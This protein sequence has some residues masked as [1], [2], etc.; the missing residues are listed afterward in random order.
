M[1][2]FC[3][4]PFCSLILF[5]VSIPSL[6]HAQSG[7]SISTGD[8]P[9][10]LI[11]IRI[12]QEGGCGTAIIQGQSVDG[13]S[14]INLSIGMLNFGD[15]ANLLL[16]GFQ[17]ILN[18]GQ[19]GIQDLIDIS[20]S[21]GCNYD[22]LHVSGEISAYVINNNRNFVLSKSMGGKVSHSDQLRI[23]APKSCIIELPVTASVGLIAF[24][25]FANPD[26]SVA[27]ASADV[28]VTMGGQ[29]VSA[30]G[31]AEVKGSGL[32]TQY[33]SSTKILK[34]QLQ[35]GVNIVPLQ[36]S[37]S[38]SVSSSV[39]GISPLNV[40][41][42]GSNAT[43]TAGNSLIVGNFTGENGEPLPEGMEIIGLTSGINYTNPT[44][45]NLCTDFPDPEVT[46][47]SASCGLANGAASVEV[48]GIDNPTYLWSTGAQTNAV[49]NLTPGLRFLIVGDTASCFKY[50]P[51]TVGDTPRPSINLP[52][53]IFLLPGNTVVLDATADNLTY[54][55]STGAVTPSITVDSPG[56]YSVTVSDQFG[57]NYEYTSEVVLKEGGLTIADGNIT[58]NSGLFFDDGGE[59]QNYQENKNYVVTIC[60]ADPDQYIRLQFTEVNI[61]N[62]TQDELSIYDGVGSLCPVNTRVT[63][64][65]I[66]TAS[67]TS[68][69]C[70]TVRFRSTSQDG[71]PPGTGWKA[72]I[73]TTTFPS[74]GCI[75]EYLECNTV[76][77][78]NGGVNSNLHIGK[79]KVYYFCPENDSD[80]AI[81]DFTQVN[82]SDLANLAVYDG[83]GIQCLL[84]PRLTTP[85]KFYASDRSGGCL[86]VVYD[87]ENNVTVAEWDALFQCTDTPVSPPEY[88]KCGINPAP[89]NTCDL[90]PLLNNIEAFCGE[91]SILYTADT[92]GNLEDA[93]GCG[94]VHN[95]SF[96]KFVPNKTSVKLRYKTRG[97]INALC[98]GF[99]LAAF[100]VEEPCNS[101]NSTWIE[102]GCLQDTNTGGDSG[103]NDEGEI[104]IS[105]LL[106]GKTYY[107]MIDGSLGSECQYTLTALSGFSACPLDVEF[108]TID[109]QPDGSFYVTIPF[110][111]IGDSTSYRLI[112]EKNFFLNL[113]EAPF[114][115]DGHTQSVTIGPY[116]PGSEYHI[117]ITGGEGFEACDLL[118][119]GRSTCEIPCNLELE[120]AFDCNEQTGETTIS[121]SIPGATRPVSIY[122][123]AFSDLI[124]PDRESDFF[125]G[126]FEKGSLGET[127]QFYVQDING[128]VLQD[129]LAVPDCVITRTNGP[130][131]NDQL[132]L[133]VFPNPA[134]SH[135][136]LLI[137][138]GESRHVLE[139]RVNILDLNG[140]IRRTLPFKGQNP[141]LL[142]DISGLPNG[143]Y[144]LRLETEHGAIIRKI[145]KV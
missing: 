98:N 33:P 76:F 41:M 63:F 18:D 77:T 6:I 54:L 19:L 47:T 59:F 61:T 4:I 143:V 79:Q 31:L 36:V 101:V 112:E 68:G 44:A 104:E 69:G 88:C 12:P 57:C 17:W 67:S 130:V 29:S 51:F 99:Q 107:L 140:I 66:Y 34:Y 116:P 60:P 97:G 58:T 16:T 136:N 81:L 125:A 25:A 21:F 126:P 9:A 35:E 80:Y 111:G 7:I 123:E 78:N 27:R 114:I 28:T 46:V 37:G 20:P 105:D 50:I 87:S 15:P 10:N 144:Y 52:E 62:S 45:S 142:M 11:K 14:S 22:I 117:R 86:T 132:S 141:K 82:I 91:S 138:T 72:Q 108:E 65:S 8:T 64:P 53:K 120:V 73:S 32:D 84:K 134:R 56:L 110:S 113:P 43:A 129:T 135:L 131:N 30:G 74:I 121:G 95:N 127:L 39:R 94:A 128:C 26:G 71:L 93:F 3:P 49:A 85:Q 23:I 124:F 55:W 48:T 137:G 109:C 118:I 145:I 13:N 133:T 96:L 38:I 139:G 106:P 75:E 102:A 42:G 100:S 5:F 90:A 83:A 103:L 2:T 1:K 115:D 92:P 89:A 119:E 24:Q 40:I 122:C 70:L